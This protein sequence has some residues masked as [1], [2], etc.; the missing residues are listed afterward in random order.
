MLF[1]FKEHKKNNN[2]IFGIVILLK[3]FVIQNLKL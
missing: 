3:S 2:K 1:I